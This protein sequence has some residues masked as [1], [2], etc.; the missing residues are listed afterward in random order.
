ME[1]LT[2]FM[3]IFFGGGLAVIAG[4]IYFW[5]IYE[6][7][8]S[9]F[10]K[11]KVWAVWYNPLYAIGWGFS[12]LLS[13]VGFLTFSAWIIK[14]GICCDSQWLLASY[15]CF[16]VSAAAYVPLLLFETGK[17]WVIFG[18]LTTA[19]CTINL[20]AWAIL[21]ISGGDLY[22]TVLLIFLAVHCTLLDLV[23]WGYYWFFDWCW[24]GTGSSL[25]LIKGGRLPEFGQEWTDHKAIVLHELPKFSIEDDPA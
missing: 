12:V 19:T 11:R 4:Y 13:M 14:N 5:R 25:K 10:E 3:I 9:D 21:H 7:L 24:V 20:S 15:L 6:T 1:S 16:V 8:Y 2:L 18:L 23:L 17:L 22:V